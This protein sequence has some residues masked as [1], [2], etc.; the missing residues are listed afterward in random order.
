VRLCVCV[1]VPEGYI[2]LL[3]CSEVSDVLIFL[4]VRRRSQLVPR[5]QQIM[6]NAFG[7]RVSGFGVRGSG[8]G[9]GFPFRMSG[10]GFRVSGSRYGFRVS[11]LRRCEAEG[12]YIYLWSIY[13]RHASTQQGLRVSGLRRCEAEGLYCLLEL[14][15]LCDC[16]SEGL[17]IRSYLIPINNIYIRSIYERHASTQQ[18]LR[19]SGFG[20][21]GMWSTGFRG[22][23]EGFRISGLGSKG[24]WG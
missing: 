12:L 4:L 23:G 2:D 13:E 22:T 9:F 3:L 14:N 6:R 24:N 16:V 11:G 21:R 15:M 5:L 1:C 8:F 18:G 10:F 19:V 7:F 20:L 17:Y